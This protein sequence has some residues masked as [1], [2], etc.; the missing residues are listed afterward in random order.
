MCF[1]TTNFSVLENF[2]TSIL[3]VQNSVIINCAQPTAQAEVDFSPNG[4]SFNW[5]QDG[6]ALTNDNIPNLNFDEAGLYAVA[7][8]HPI[9][10]CVVLDSI[11]VVEDF[12]IP[13]ITTGVQDTISCLA[14]LVTI[15]G[16]TVWAAHE[17]SVSWNAALGSAI[18]SPFTN[19]PQVNESD[20]YSI[21]VTDLVNGCQNSA[22]V[23]VAAEELQAIDPTFLVFPNTVTPNQDQYNN[24]WRVYLKYN[25]EV[26]QHELFKDWSLIIFDRWGKNV[27]QIDS[28]RQTWN[29]SEVV[30]GVYYYT[31]E[32]TLLCGEEQAI[33]QEGYIHVM[34]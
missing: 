21:E 34:R 15:N 20:V 9:S 16:V 33:K 30:E 7:A 32:A 3:E 17:Y 13:I 5:F 27:A 29:A 19:A 4:T 25:A 23:F 14:P 8:T 10:G 2:D 1:A 28:P 11:Q 6:A 31:L 22:S 12:V 18:F 26:P 24:D